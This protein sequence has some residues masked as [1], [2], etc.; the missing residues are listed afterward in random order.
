MRDGGLSR[1]AARA[2]EDGPRRLRGPAIN[3]MATL[4]GLG[5]FWGLVWALLR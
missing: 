5:A 1:E 3:V 2:F 4:V